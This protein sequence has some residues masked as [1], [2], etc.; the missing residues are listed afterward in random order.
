MRELV[1][2]LMDLDAA[3]IEQL[4]IIDGQIRFRPVERM[5]SDLLRRLREH[6]AELL[7]HLPGGAPAPEGLVLDSDGW[8]VGSFE[9]EPCTAC[10]GLERWQDATGAWHCQHCDRRG[11]ERSLALVGDDSLLQGTKR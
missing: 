3:G 4:A 1:D 11:L 8:P 7:A 2:L 5:T 6:K 9:P 10:G